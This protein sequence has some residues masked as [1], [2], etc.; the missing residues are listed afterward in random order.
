MGSIVPSRQGYLLGRA[1]VL[2]PYAATG[3]TASL[4]LANTLF[5]CKIET[6]SSA[7][8]P[9]HLNACLQFL[10]FPEMDNRINTVDTAENGTCE[11][12]FQHDVY[13]SWA[14]CNRSLLWIKGKPGSG[15]STLLRHALDH[16]LD[17][18]EPL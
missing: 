1:M 14:A 5:A 3:L 6:R 12:L 9:A 17:H 18:A 2:S 16:A 13:K 7:Q 11:W 15:K 4:V 8:P 10:A